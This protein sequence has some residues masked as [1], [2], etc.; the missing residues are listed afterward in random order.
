[1]DVYAVVKL[2]GD[3]WPIIFENK[4]NTYLH[5]DQF[6]NYCKK[7]AGWDKNKVR[8]KNILY[9][10]YKTGYPFGW[11]RKDFE[12]QI[13]ETQHD[14]E[15][16]TKLKVKEIYL[17]DMVEFID[18]Q[19]K[20]NL[21]EDYY[22][23]LKAQAERRKFTLEKGLKTVDEFEKSFD[24]EEGSNDVACSMLVEK[25]FGENCKFNYNHQQWASKDLFVTCD[26]EIEE[27]R[28]YYLYRI[29]KCSY[30]T[31]NHKVVL[32]LQQHR[33]ENKV[34][35][36]KTK[37]LKNKIEEAKTIQEICERIT[38]KMDDL[39]ESIRFENLHENSDKTYDGKMIMKIFIVGEN[40]PEKVCEY[41]K[42]FTEEL[43]EEVIKQ[44]KNKVKLVDKFTNE[45]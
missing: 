26:D 43:R 37:A 35:E 19:D 18:K 3:F 28:I 32:Q 5:D 6:N 8:Y 11:Q 45:I 9:V 38:E 21:L 20:D 44:F 12:R 36:N 25:I 31:G 27:N 16:D 29:A 30:T 2:R 23:Y 1:M 39:K 15:K 41:V 10:Y 24:N 33:Y 7:V 34:K 40:T 14:L 42:K 4:T 22:E 13:E 17:E